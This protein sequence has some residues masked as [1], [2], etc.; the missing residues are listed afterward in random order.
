MENRKNLLIKIE[1]I[2]QLLQVEAVGGGDAIMA[3][4]GQNLQLW[5]DLTKNDSE[6]ELKV[7]F[8]VLVEHQGA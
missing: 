8:G 7:G 3:I 2:G 4:D 5:Q 6:E 1:K